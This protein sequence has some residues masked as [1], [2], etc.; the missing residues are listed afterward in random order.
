[1]NNIY[2]DPS[3]KKVREMMTKKLYELKEKYKDPDP[4]IIKKGE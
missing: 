2:N 3:Y 4:V 1:M